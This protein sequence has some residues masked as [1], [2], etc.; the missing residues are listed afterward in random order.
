MTVA[1]DDLDARDLAIYLERAW[2]DEALADD[3]E[4]VA[5]HRL[6]RI[7]RHGQAEAGLLC[8]VFKPGWGGRVAMRS[9]VECECTR[10]PW[11]AEAGS[12]VVANQSVD[13]PTADGYSLIS[14]DELMLLRDTLERLVDRFDA[15]E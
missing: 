6:V 15:I 4:V 11:R 5:N 1:D 2:A 3:P 13:G 7:E 14:V 10:N 8:E 9:A 12:A